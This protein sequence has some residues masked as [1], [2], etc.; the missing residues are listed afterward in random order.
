MGGGYGLY[1]YKARTT[2]PAFIDKRLRPGMTYSYRL[3][4]PEVEQEVVMAQIKTSTF[5][6]ESL[7]SHNSSSQPGVSTASVVAAPTALP[8]DTVLLGLVS[9]NDFTDDFNTL[10]LVG[11]VRN[12]SNLDV[13]QTDITVTFYDAAG[14]VI[15]VAHGETLFD[16]IPPGDK[17][18]FHITLTHPPGFASYSLRVIARPVL[19]RQSA[20]LAVIELKRFEDA[21]GFFHIK[22]IIENVGNSVAGRTKVT[23]IIYGRDGGIINVGFTYVNPST[24]APG[25]QATYDV[26]FAYYPQYLT[27]Q[28]IPFEE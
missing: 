15:G 17:S 25:E 21:A 6:D 27:Q 8:R 4:R 1:V 26:I 3:T 12:D 2:Q 7:T 10:T 28:V 5:A 22:G 18:P 11:E 19:P 13:G 24:L 14:I 20:Q 9:N 23:A 16:I